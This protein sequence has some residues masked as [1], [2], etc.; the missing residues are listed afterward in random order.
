VPFSQGLPDGAVRDRIADTRNPIIPLGKPAVMSSPPTVST[1]TTATLSKHVIWS[2]PGIRS[3]YGVPRDLGGFAVVEIPSMLGVS[4][5]RY[6]MCLEFMTDS[7][8]F[9]IK[10][11]AQGRYFRIWVDGQFITATDNNCTIMAASNTAYTKVDFGSRAARHIRVE[12]DHGIAVYGIQV[13]PLASVWA[14]GTPSGPKVGWLGDSWIQNSS[15]VNQRMRGIAYELSR[16]LKWPSLITSALDGTGYLKTNTTTTPN[17]PKFRDRLQLDIIDQ[18]CDIVVVWGSVTDANAGTAAN[19]IAAEAAI[20]YDAIRAGLPH[21]TLIVI[22]PQQSQSPVPAISTQ[23]N[24]AIA[25]VA[26]EKADLFV[27][28]LTTPYITGTGNTAAPNGTG[29]ADWYIT[30]QHPVNEGCEYIGRRLAHAIAPH[31]PALGLPY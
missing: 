30:T 15:P 8:A 11:G 3:R 29:N 25:A 26:A 18:A 27:D 31:L 23:H 5:V 22:G 10:Y 21:A 1:G 24:A 6:P 7:S 16:L 2:D 28:Q 13:D 4:T 19:L 12:V 20:L 14:P 9:E 17:Y